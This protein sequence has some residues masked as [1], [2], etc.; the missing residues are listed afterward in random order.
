MLRRLAL[1]L[2]LALAL[3]WPTFALAARTTATSRRPVATG[4]SDRTD[5]SGSKRM[6]ARAQHAMAAD[7]TGNVYVFGG[8]GTDRRYLADLWRYSATTDRW[9]AVEPQ[10]EVVPPPLVEPHLV[11]DVNG[12]LYEFGGKFQGGPVTNVFYRFDAAAGR[13]VDLRHTTWGSGVPARED[14]GVALDPRRRQ[15]YVFGGMGEVDLLNDF[16][17]Y[18]IA[19]GRWEDLT[20]A[21]GSSRMSPREIYNITYDN[22]RYLYLFAGATRQGLVSDFW[23]Y[24]LDRGVWEEITDQTGAGQI[25]ARH[26]YGQ[27]ADADGNFYVLGGY[28]GATGAVLADFWVYD[29]NSGAWAERG[30]GS[31]APLPRIP[32]VLAFLPQSGR[33]ITFGGSSGGALR[34]DTWTYELPGWA[35]TVSDELTRRHFLPNV[36]VRH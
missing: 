14:H 33:L 5:E 20:A 12:D 21:S 18:D 13:W 36:R 28:Q 1:P 6:P 8:V 19:T 10:S 34:N 3:L 22:D 7:P 11:A 24:D 23:R 17:R 26:Y 32:Y 35:P 9:E 4:W 31:A 30:A 27:A 2:L 29:A 16:W 25:P 15:I